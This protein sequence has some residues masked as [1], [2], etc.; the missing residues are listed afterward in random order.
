MPA[1]LQTNK[2]TNLFNALV[3]NLF[4]EHAEI[5]QFSCKQQ[6]KVTKVKKVVAKLSIAE[7][8]DHSEYINK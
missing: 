8:R 1:G 7:K 2:Q 5:E 3:Y 4:V 6:K